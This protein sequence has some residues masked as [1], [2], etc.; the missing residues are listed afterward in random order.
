MKFT[1]LTGI[2]AVSIWLLVAFSGCLPGTYYGGENRFGDKW[3]AVVE[4]DAPAETLFSRFYY[5]KQLPQ[6]ERENEYEKV[7]TRLE[8]EP[9]IFW[10]LEALYL[11]ILTGHPQKGTAL[12][13]ALKEEIGKQKYENDFELKG[14]VGLLELLL[15]QKNEIIFTQRLLEEEKDKS[16]KL[17]HQLKEL[18]NIEKIIHERETSKDNE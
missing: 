6:E 3:E 7:L 5:L 10:Q 9:D 15:K 14:V 12:L 4:K 18:K 16:D 2:P 8:H 17:A 13:S 1:K 11:A